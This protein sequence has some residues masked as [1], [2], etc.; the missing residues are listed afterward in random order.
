MGLTEQRV[1]LYSGPKRNFGPSDYG[2]NS[3]FERRN[4][5]ATSVRYA[6]FRQQF[7]GEISAYSRSNAWRP[8]FACFRRTPREGDRFG[9]KILGSGW[10][11]VRRMVRFRR[12]TVAHERAGAISRRAGHIA[13]LVSLRH[14]LVEG[15]YD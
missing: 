3:I 11:V 4:A 7:V 6:L 12:D 15:V 8:D 14:H 2:R 5:A 10:R 13:T 9:H 1:F